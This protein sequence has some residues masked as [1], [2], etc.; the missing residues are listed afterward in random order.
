MEKL[1]AH[2]P[3]YDLGITLVNQFHQA[4]SCHQAPAPAIPELSET[5]RAQLLSLAERMLGLAAELKAE[6]ALAKAQGQEGKALCLI[7]LQLIQEETGELA[8][9]MGNQ[10][11]VEALDALT[12]I[13]YVVDGTY[14]TLGMGHL[15]LA[16]LR[17]VHRSNMSKLGADGKPIISDAGRVVKGPTYSPPDLAPLLARR[18]L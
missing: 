1:S 6:A 2:F 14:L 12:D 18:A 11:P 10:D 8:E 15:K 4:F 5:E 16:A 3:G 7:R 9:A 13:T 17:E